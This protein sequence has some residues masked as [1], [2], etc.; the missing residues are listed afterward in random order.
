MVLQQ[1]RL[2]R[3]HGR[4][5]RALL[6]SSNRNK[7]KLL[8]PTYREK[9]RIRPAFTQELEPD[10]HKSSLAYVQRPVN[11]PSERYLQSI[12]R[13]PLGATYDLREVLARVK[14]KVGSE[15]TKVAGADHS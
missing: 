8:E 13:F 9:F 14:S 15:G 10:P 2:R 3:R 1:I 7:A 12:E 11:F 4:F 6:F 5:H